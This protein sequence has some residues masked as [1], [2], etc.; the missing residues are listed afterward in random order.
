MFFIIISGNFC[1]T[2]RHPHKSH[3]VHVRHCHCPSCSAVIVSKTNFSRH[4]N[5]QICSTVE[6]VA[7]KA[8]R[9]VFCLFFYRFIFSI[10][11][12]CFVDTFI[13]LLLYCMTMVIVYLYRL[14]AMLL[15]KSFNIYIFIRH[16]DRKK[17]KKN[18]HEQLSI[19]NGIQC[20]II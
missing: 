3:N 11:T 9:L 4:V 14:N 18:K 16:E 17:T 20:T 13:L 1:V 6:E 5:E 8:L 7:R 2:C 12:I 19:T 10:K 15:I